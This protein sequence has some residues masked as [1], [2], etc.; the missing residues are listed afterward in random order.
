[1]TSSLEA[2]DETGFAAIGV[3]MGWA[4]PRGDGV[5]GLLVIAYGCTSVLLPVSEDLLQPGVQ[6]KREAARRN[7]THEVSRPSYL[8]IISLTADLRC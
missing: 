3:A 4:M 6:N 5:E 2:G 8:H 1:M 7:R